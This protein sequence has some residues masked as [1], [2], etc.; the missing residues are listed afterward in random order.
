MI[1]AEQIE[2]LPAALELNY[3]TFRESIRDSLEEALESGDAVRDMQTCLG[4][5]MRALSHTM[6]EYG[7]PEGTLEQVLSIL[8]FPALGGALE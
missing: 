7:A 8:T 4:D 1:T 6:N 5:F 2:L 3:F